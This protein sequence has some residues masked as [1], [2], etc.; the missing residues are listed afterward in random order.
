MSVMVVYHPDR[1][2]EV[3]LTEE[4]GEVR[5]DRESSAPT[6]KSETASA[7]STPSTSQARRVIR[8]ENTGFLRSAR[9]VRPMAEIFEPLELT[10]PGISGEKIWALTTSSSAR[11]N[12][13]TSVS[14]QLHR[15]WPRAPPTA[16]SSRR[17]LGGIFPRSLRFLSWSRTSDHREGGLVRH[18]S[19]E[20]SRPP[21]SPRTASRRVSGAARPVTPEELK[22]S[23]I[24]REFSK[25]TWELL[26]QPGRVREGD[27][28]P[29]RVLLGEL[30]ARALEAGGR[31]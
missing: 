8:V 22:S 19:Q 23:W 13:G 27:R 31:P 17:T 12:L 26:R 21:M 10:S 28:H 30:Q 11:G 4:L 25:N 6:T 14:V 15:I 5:V 2:P 29:R 20:N 7:A 9:V 3:E 24:E 16:S 1:P 18:S